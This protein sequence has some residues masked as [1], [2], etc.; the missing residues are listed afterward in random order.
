MNPRRTKN[1]QKKKTVRNAAVVVIAASLIGTIIAYNYY[2]DQNMQKGLKF[3]TE[4]ERIQNDIKNIQDEFYSEK[5]MWEEGDIS[6]EELFAFYEKH[7]VRF[8]DAI[9]MYDLL[10]APE[11]FEGSVQLLKLSSETQLESDEEFIEWMRTGDE[12]AIVRSDVLFQDALEYE[13]HGLIEFYSAKTGVKTFD[14]SGVQFEAPQRGIMERIN[15]VWNH[16][17][18]ECNEKFGVV[19]DAATSVNMEED[20]MATSVSDTTD[21]ELAN[22]MTKAEEWRDMHMP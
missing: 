17:I 7:T 15:M 9:G 20:E 4:L 11:I 10:E 13:M 12:E 18:A 3:G 2:V 22:C 19:D 14:E 21:P 5:A 6:H 16:M 8:E 1:R